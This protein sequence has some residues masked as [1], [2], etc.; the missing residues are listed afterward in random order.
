MHKKIALLIN[1][2]ITESPYNHF[3]CDVISN[4]DKT[5][6]FWSCIIKFAKRGDAHSDSLVKSLYYIGMVYGEGLCITDKGVMISYL[7]L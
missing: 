3:H 6:G 1:K 5:D 7:F 2:M 4:P